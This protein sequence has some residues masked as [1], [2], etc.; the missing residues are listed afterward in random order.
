[1]GFS[2]KK[3]PVAQAKVLFCCEK[4]QFQLNLLLRLPNC[5]SEEIDIELSDIELPTGLNPVASAIRI[6]QKFEIAYCG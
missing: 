5:I 4:E 1:M 2:H 3:L 6:E